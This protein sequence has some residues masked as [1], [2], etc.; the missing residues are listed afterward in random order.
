MSLLFFGT[1]SW[2]W[3]TT[4][5]VDDGFHINPTSSSN[6]GEMMI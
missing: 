4:A 1:K 6:P 3:C 5:C 2:Y